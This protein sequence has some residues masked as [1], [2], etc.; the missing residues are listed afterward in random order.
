MQSVQLE[1]FNLCIYFH[2]IARWHHSQNGYRKEKRM[3]V[4]LI[5][6]CRFRT[7]PDVGP[8]PSPKA[9]HDTASLSTVNSPVLVADASMYSALL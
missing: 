4:Q 2:S 7:H 9:R 1:V 6:S 5:F 8:W 3:S